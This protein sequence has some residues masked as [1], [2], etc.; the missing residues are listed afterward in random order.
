[1]RSLRNTVSLHFCTLWKVWPSAPRS[2]GDQAAS[3]PQ[4]PRRSGPLRCTRGLLTLAL[5]AAP[6]ASL[7]RRVQVLPPARSG[8]QLALRTSL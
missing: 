2:P 6:R 3:G 7:R 1:M 5:S 8:Y 4:G